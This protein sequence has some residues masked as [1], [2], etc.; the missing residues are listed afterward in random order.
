[1]GAP[2]QRCDPEGNARSLEGRVVRDF[3]VRERIAEGGFGAVHRAEQPR[4]SREAV[5][6]FLHTRDGAESGELRSRFLREVQLASHFEHPFAAHVY[7]F[8]AEPDG[9]LWIAMERVH[10]VSLSD[11]IA[12]YGPFAPTRF[13]PLCERICEVVQSAHDQGIVHR[14]LKPANVM[15]LERAGNLLPKLLDFGVARAQ[16]DVALADRNKLPESEHRPP[17]ESRSALATCSIHSTRTG[18]TVGSP[19]YMAPE[20]WEDPA[21]AGP[22]ADMYA[23]GVLCYEALTGRTPFTGANI[24]EVARAHASQP[25]PPLDPARRT[26][27]DTFFDRALA[28]KPAERFGS[29]L[30][31][32]KEFCRAAAAAHR[33]RAARVGLTV[34]ALFALAIASLL[35]VRW[36]RALPATGRRLAIVAE[37]AGSADAD[38]LARVIERLALRKLGKTERRFEVL[39]SAAGANVVAHLR[40]RREREGIVLDGAV[41]PAH[42]GASSVGSFRAA[43]LAKALDAALSAIATTAGAGQ[44]EPGPTQA[45]QREMSHLGTASF[46][47]FRAYKTLYDDTIDSD[48]S[49]AFEERAAAVAA[50][51][52]GWAHGYLELVYAQGGSTERARATIARARASVDRSRDPGGQMLLDMEAADEPVGDRTLEVLERSVRE[53][54]EDEL[55]SV[56]LAMVYRFVGRLD[57][58]VA[59]FRRLTDRNPASIYGSAL[60]NTL[61]SVG[62]Q[63]EASEVREHWFASAPEGRWATSARILLDLSKNDLARAEQRARDLVFLYGPESRALRILCEVL[64]IAGK[65]K[66]ASAVIEPLLQGSLLDRTRGQ[67]RL[68]VA[69]ILEGRFAAAFVSLEQSLSAVKGEG[70][71]GHP[72]FTLQQLRALAPIVKADVTPFLER[73]V[74]LMGVEPRAGILRYEIALTKPGRH[75][76]PDAEVV[77]ARLP[78]GQRVSAQ[79]VMLRAAAQVACASCAQVVAAGLAPAEP[80]NASLLDFAVCAEREGKFE[81]ARDALARV[82]EMR[83][84]SLDSYAGTWSIFAAV[85]ARFHLGRVLERLGDTAGARAAYSS[86]LER[87]DHADR[88]LP[89]VD[90]ARQALQRLH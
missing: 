51:D 45:E 80:K 30:E 38:W 67:V 17:G 37:N 53:A 70:S 88:P 60:M 18:H 41:G 5:L 76:C 35:F 87:W 73:E 65:T 9:L 48:D 10:G 79:R 50:L 27:L 15:V 77:L 34:G 56:E 32:S 66:E 23:L 1:M 26:P 68:G 62:R 13:A 59:L 22:P 89:E 46:T 64:L 39:G 6:K 29:V 78:P 7:D 74:E 49:F 58:S 90:E 12:R 28:K 83:M 81:L 54:P 72:L 16:G 55:M 19:A 42:G 21:A 44:P 84:E 43:S 82:G 20:Q 25:V 63:R 75:G 61:E 3:L 71:Q 8:G 86:F 31:L 24:D 4:L 52:P 69:A 2:D 57:E 14:D 85:L 33:P 11:Y 40:Y 47:A 36:Y